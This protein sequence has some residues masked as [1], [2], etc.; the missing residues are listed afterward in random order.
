MLDAKFGLLA[1]LADGP[2]KVFIL[3]T[4]LLGAYGKIASLAAEIQTNILPDCK[5]CFSRRQ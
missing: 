4:T 2:E 5:K 1:A 3:K